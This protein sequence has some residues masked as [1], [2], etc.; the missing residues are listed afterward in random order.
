M[1]NRYRFS[2]PEEDAMCNEW[3]KKQANVSMS[4]RMLIRDFVRIYGNKDYFSVDN[5]SAPSMVQASTLQQEDTTVAPKVSN[6][7]VTKP[8]KQ[9]VL[10]TPQPVTQQVLPSQ[11]VQQPSQPVVP[12]VAQTVGNT[13]NKLRE[14]LM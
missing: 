3:L 5:F 11:M 2:V 7:S 1:T 10:S 6:T 14:M 4:V 8:K 12:Q 13:R 9:E